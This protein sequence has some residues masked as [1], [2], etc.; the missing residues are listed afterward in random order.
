MDCISYEI[1]MQPEEVVD[2][3]YVTLE[4]MIIWGEKGKIVKST[5]DRFLKYQSKIMQKGD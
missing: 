3:K 2:V 4:E 5:W 1:K